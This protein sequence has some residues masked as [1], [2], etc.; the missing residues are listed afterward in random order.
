MP[1]STISLHHHPTIHYSGLSLSHVAPQFSFLDHLH[2]LSA[3]CFPTGCLSFSRQLAWQPQKARPIL[4]SYMRKNEIVGTASKSY[5][6]LS[7]QAEVRLLGDEALNRAVV[8]GFAFHAY[9][10][11][12]ILQNQIDSTKNARYSSVKF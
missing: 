8:G 4:P 5:L 7:L 1:V 11:N 3:M 10:T 2:Q 6:C 12:I 9:K